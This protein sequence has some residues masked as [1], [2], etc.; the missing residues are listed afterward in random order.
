M[1]T[2]THAEIDIENTKSKVFKMLDLCIEAIQD[3]ITALKTL[4]ARKARKIISGDNTIDLLEKAID[5]DCIKIIV[6]RQPAATDLRLI[7][8][9][10]KINTELERTADLAVTIAKQVKN[11]EGQSLIK[12]LIDIP[13]MAEIVVQMNITVLD[14]FTEKNIEKAEN[15]IKHD[16]II[17]NLNDQVFREL[18]T[19]M[20]E[21]P[22]AVTQSIALIRIAKALERMGDHATNIAE[23]VIFYINGD[24]VRHRQIS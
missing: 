1:H 13:R 12:P 6:T 7:L 14:S 24:D 5:H 11:L 15:V 2:V 17:D 21:H 9:M 20:A 10:M 22:A 19:I 18:T 4:D 23:Q 16:D 3:S 8:A